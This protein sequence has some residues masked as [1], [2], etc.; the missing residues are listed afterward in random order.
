MSGKPSS[1]GRFTLKRLA[2][3]LA[4]LAVTWWFFEV[5]EVPTW[6]LLTVIAVGGVA[7]LGVALLLAT[8]QDLH[9]EDQVLVWTRPGAAK[10]KLAVADLVSIEDRRLATPKAPQL[11]IRGRGGVEIIVD[12]TAL[13][14]RQ[15]AIVL[16]RLREMRPDLTVPDL[17]SDV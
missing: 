1:D 12:S 13:D 8:S 4:T 17:L 15:I 16:A 2:I 11:R 10:I 6:A 7:I 3:V 14:R 5:V 9:L